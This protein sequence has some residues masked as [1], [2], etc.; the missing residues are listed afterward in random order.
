M[1]RKKVYNDIMTESNTPFEVETPAVVKKTSHESLFG[2]LIMMIVVVFLVLLASYGGWLLYRGVSESR[3]DPNRISI[4]NIPVGTSAEN[5]SKD[6]GIVPDEGTAPAAPFVVN[7]KIGIKVLNGGG[8]KGSASV[9]AGVLMGAGYATVATGNANGNYTGVI[10]YFSGEA[11]SGDADAVVAALLKKYPT[12]VTK[13]A[14]TG[15]ADTSAAP[16]TV[17]VGK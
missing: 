6:A 1:K 9:V 3:P 13:P 11:V 14:I 8:A 5:A 10:V 12:S 16:V 17:L 4:E 15:N 7:K 2:F